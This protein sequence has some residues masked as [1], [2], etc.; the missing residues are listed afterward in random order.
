LFL[1]CREGGKKLPNDVALEFSKLFTELKEAKE[2]NKAKKHLV[3]LVDFSAVY[4]YLGA[5]FLPL[6]TEDQR[7]KL[8]NDSRMKINETIVETL[9]PQSGPAPVELSEAC[10]RAIVLRSTEAS[11]RSELATIVSTEASK[12]AV[13]HCLR[14]FKSQKKDDQIVKVFTDYTQDT[15]YGNK[16]QEILFSEHLCDYLPFFIARIDLTNPKSAEYQEFLSLIDKA[17]QKP[18]TVLPV[19]SKLLTMV[20]D[21]SDKDFNNKVKTVAATVFC[22]LLANRDSAIFSNL[23]HKNSSNSVF[24]FIVYQLLNQL[25]I[26]KSPE[27][28]QFD[29]IK[30]ELLGSD[31]NPRE[32]INLLNAALGVDALSDNPSALK[33]RIIRPDIITT[34]LLSSKLTGDHKKAILEYGSDF[35]NSCVLISHHNRNLAI[36]AMTLFLN[37]GCTLKPEY[38]NDSSTEFNRDNPLHMAAFLATTDK[39][40]SDIF[41][42]LLSKVNYVKTG[43]LEAM[44]KLGVASLSPIQVLFKHAKT[45]NYT[46]F[47]KDQSERLL[48]FCA[49]ELDLE[50]INTDIFLFLVDQ[51]LK[52][53]LK[54]IEIVIKNIDNNEQKKRQLLLSLRSQFPDLA[55]EYAILN[56]NPKLAE[57]IINSGKFDLPQLRTILE[58]IAKIAEAKPDSDTTQ[59]TSILGRSYLTACSD[60]LS[61]PSELSDIERRNQCLDKILEIKPLLHSSC[62]PQIVAMIIQMIKQN[63]NG[64]ADPKMDS[65]LK[66]FGLTDLFISKKYTNNRGIFSSGPKYTTSQAL[67]YLRLVDSNEERFLQFME[68]CYDT[69]NWPSDRATQNSYTQFMALVDE[70]NTTNSA[71]SK[72]LLNRVGEKRLEKIQEHRSTPNP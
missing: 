55:I 19:L 35:L 46:I 66:D 47:E 42:L 70:L 24:G 5:R 34:V 8:L 67:A 51:G 6:M 68:K 53:N 7:L 62:A 12:S 28:R 30:E 31:V 50:G 71:L 44:L 49:K 57:E 58:K 72:I 16:L 15:N 40:C 48:A 21:T 54:Q 3:Q 65:F 63:Q 52:P 36:E 23:R 33:N 1:N 10:V 61:E 4:Q 25:F 56:N 11:K 60:I 13:A 69:R 37:F 59:L 43:V 38:V 9:I 26:V 20:G 45:N 32:V 17:V 64:K 18:N 29:A 22:N 14:V 41:E 2:A 39:N 27:Y